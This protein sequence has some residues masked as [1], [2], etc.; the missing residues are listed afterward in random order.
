MEDLAFLVG[1]I[2][3]GLFML[4]TAAVV[5]AALSR[6]NKIS[7]YWGLGLGVVLTIIAMIAWQGSER[8]ALVPLAWGVLAGVISMWPKAK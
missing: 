5:L 3:I 6:R 4:G 8:L 7:R 2:L 1:G